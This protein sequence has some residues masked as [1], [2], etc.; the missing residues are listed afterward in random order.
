MLASAAYVFKHQ[1]SANIVF[2]RLAL[3]TIG[4]I[5]KELEVP[6]SKVRISNKLG[7]RRIPLNNGNPSSC[8]RME[9]GVWM[10]LDFDGKCDAVQ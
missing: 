8:V 3:E 5:L 1:L 6:P 10:H 7:W 2:V 9:P 4:S